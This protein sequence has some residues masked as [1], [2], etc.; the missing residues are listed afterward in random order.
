MAQRPAQRRAH[1][2]LPEPLVKEIDRLVG[3]RG[4]SGFLVEA[5]WREIRRLQ[6]LETLEKVA[7]KWSDTM[8]PELKQGASP[9]ISYLRGTDEKRLRELTKR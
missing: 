9:W 7:G 2:I 4:R 8:H 5:A 3:N 1:V 6:L